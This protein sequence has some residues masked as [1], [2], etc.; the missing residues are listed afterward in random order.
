MHKLSD[1]KNAP[2]KSVMAGMKESGKASL[3]YSF[4]VTPTI[5]RDL[6][7]KD[8][9]ERPSNMRKS[10]RYTW[11]TFFPIAFGLQFKKLVNIFYI[12]T[13]VLNMFRTI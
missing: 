5:Y 3:L 11:V 13:G 2:P 9:A 8:Q 1:T 10:T 7:T 4:G 12:L 6:V